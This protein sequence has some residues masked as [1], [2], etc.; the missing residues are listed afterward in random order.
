MTPPEKYS[1]RPTGLSRRTEDFIFRFNGR[2]V[3][4][5]YAE[6]TPTGQRWYWSIYSIKLR[7]P[8]P[9]SIILRG[10][11]NDL[12]EANVAFRENWEK[13]LDA[14]RVQKEIARR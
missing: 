3:G 8:I 6:T 9:E 11:A 14:G 7:G 12:E 5:I 4:R 1:L 10:L 2:D 13:L